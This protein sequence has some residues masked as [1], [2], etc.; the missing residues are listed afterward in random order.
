MLFDLFYFPPD[1]LPKR[2]LFP[3]LYSVRVHTQDIEKRHKGRSNQH[4]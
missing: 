1:C 2:S 4:Q 3:I